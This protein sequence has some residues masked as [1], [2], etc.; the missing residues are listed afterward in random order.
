VCNRRTLDEIADDAVA[1]IDPPAES[2]EACR[3]LVMKYLTKLSR[4]QLKG[5]MRGRAAITRLKGYARALHVAK[6]KAQAVDAVWGM[7]EISVF[8]EDWDGDFSFIDLLDEELKRVEELLE[9]PCVTLLSKR[10]KGKHPKDPYAV[11]AV[12]MAHDLIDRDCPWRQKPTLTTKGP[13]L[14]LS[15]LLYEAGTGKAGRDLSRYCRQRWAAGPTKIT[16]SNIGPE[17]GPW[18]EWWEWE[19]LPLTDTLP[20]PPPEGWPPAAA[21]RKVCRPRW[22]AD[23]R[24]KLNR[25]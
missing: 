22:A 11:E 19:D 13:W 15:R 14:R 20:R 1:V 21:W 17:G 6:W 18:H 25:R 7:P 10:Q 12:K 5:E 8:D 3:A 2:K 24:Q 23:A 9:S 16:F 4:V